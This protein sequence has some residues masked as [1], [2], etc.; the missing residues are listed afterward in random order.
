MEKK[1]GNLKNKN[2]ELNEEIIK[3]SIQ[4]L[5]LENPHNF[6]ADVLVLGLDQ[7]N[8]VIFFN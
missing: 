2:E 1:I 3:Y 6:S 4:N 5:V 7:F 8:I